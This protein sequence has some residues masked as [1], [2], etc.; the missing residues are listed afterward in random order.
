MK[1]ERVVEKTVFLRLFS[2]KNI[3]K[4]IIEPTTFAHYSKI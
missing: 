1:R 3:W 4:K 2:A